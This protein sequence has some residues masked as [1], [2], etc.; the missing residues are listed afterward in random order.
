M[1]ARERNTGK[2]WDVNVQGT[3]CNGTPIRY[4]TSDF[5]HL[6]NPEDLDFDVPDGEGPVKVS[7]GGFDRTAFRSQAA[8]DILCSL[9]ADGR[10]IHTSTAG[11]VQ[12]AVDVADMLMERLGI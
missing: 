12:K 9:L 8:K 3:D 6:F 1:K 11:V 2:T 10:D 4:C 5:R 7:G